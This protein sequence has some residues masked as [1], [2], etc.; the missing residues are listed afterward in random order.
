M[1]V[2]PSFPP[3]EDDCR[4]EDLCSAAIA[5]RENREKIKGPSSEPWPLH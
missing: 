1:K 3:K 4:R 2:A 5:D